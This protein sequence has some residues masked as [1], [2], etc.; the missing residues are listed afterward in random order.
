[1]ATGPLDEAEVVRR[2]LHGDRAAY[3]TL[4]ERYQSIALRTAYAIT[5][6]S[7]DAEEV[8]QDAFVKAHRSLPR[9]RRHEPF[10][11]WLLTIVGNE[12]RNRRRA[13]GS[14]PVVVAS[15]DD[16][17]THDPAPSPDAAVLAADTRQALGVAL[18]A[19]S[20]DDRDV[21]GCRFFLDLSEAET[22]SVLGIRRGTVKSRLSRALERLR[23]SL[24]ADD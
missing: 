16:E 5:G 23:A 2:V 3:R 4:V 14:R 11:P 15:S 6:S 10:R 22:A 9:F 21:I 8:V 1:V 7:R 24:E 17:R 19:L 13:N 12:A 20:Q 18:A